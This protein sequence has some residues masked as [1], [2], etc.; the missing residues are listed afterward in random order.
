MLLRVSSII[1]TALA[2]LLYG[3]QE[4]PGPPAGS[5]GRLL[6]GPLIGGDDSSMLRGC[7][8]KRRVDVSERALIGGVCR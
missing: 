7:T 6:Q 2:L 1:V 3:V 8:R 4:R 5:Q